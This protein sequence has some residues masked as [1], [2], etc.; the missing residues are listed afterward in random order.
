MILNIVFKPKTEDLEFYH[1]NMIKS[2]IQKILNYP[3]LDYFYRD[4]CQHFP[5]F[6]AATRFLDSKDTLVRITSYNSFL[7]LLKNENF[8]IYLPVIV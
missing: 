6:L 4:N 5:L 3:P 1:V 2:I 8:Q 7:N